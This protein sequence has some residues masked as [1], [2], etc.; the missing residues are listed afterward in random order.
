MNN[1]FFC[2]DF[3]SLPLFCQHYSMKSLFLFSL[4]RPFRKACI[5]AANHRH[6]QQISFF[7]LLLNS[8]TFFFKYYFE[9]DEDTETF[10]EYLAFYLELFCNMFFMFEM[11]L[12]I[13]AKGF[14]LGK[15]T[16]FKSGWRIMD[17]SCLLF[18]YQFYERH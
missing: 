11:G 10:R 17:F 15:Q 12:L 13:I 14:F 2:C 18:R 7:F 1:Y 8:L 5:N 16:Y 3:S 6:F 9:S 4:H